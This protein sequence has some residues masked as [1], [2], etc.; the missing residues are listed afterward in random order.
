MDITKIRTIHG[1]EELGNLSLWLLAD[2]PA[3]IPVLH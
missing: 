2:V 1:L 3:T